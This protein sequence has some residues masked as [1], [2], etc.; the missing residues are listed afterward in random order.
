MPGKILG[1]WLIGIGLTIM[2]GPIAVF[3][4]VTAFSSF[5]RDNTILFWHYA[6]A[7]GAIIYIPVG[8]IIVVIGLMARQRSFRLIFT[9]GKLKTEE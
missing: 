4:F 5:F 6:S 1:Y 9:S 7:F 3:L 2:L 8:L